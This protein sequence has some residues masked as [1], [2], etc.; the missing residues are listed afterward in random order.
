MTSKESL[1]I[2]KT[3]GL[4]TMFF[5]GMD[6]TL[7]EMNTAMIERLLKLQAKARNAE[8][9]RIKDAISGGG[10]EDEEMKWR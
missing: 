8:F 2:Y 3:D 10:K 4:G 9:N 5:L 1:V 6:G 7:D